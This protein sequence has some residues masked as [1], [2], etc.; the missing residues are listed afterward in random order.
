MHTHTHTHTH[1][2]T[3]TNAHIHT[4][5]HRTNAPASTHKCMMC[6][7][8]VRVCPYTH[9]Q[10]HRS[11]PVYKPK[12]LKAGRGRFNQQTLEDLALV[13]LFCRVPAS[14]LQTA[15]SFAKF[16]YEQKCDSSST[17]KHKVARSVRTART[18]GTPS[19]QIGQGVHHQ[20]R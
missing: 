10:T 7:C 17:G 8:T 16:H 15:S 13:N 11:I 20:N 3:H 18:G 12:Q 19:E 6:I 9:T 5:S 14:A 2:C 4:L 1:T